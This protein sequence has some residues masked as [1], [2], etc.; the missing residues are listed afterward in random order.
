MGK[1]NWR[2]DAGAGPTQNAAYGPERVGRTYDSKLSTTRHRWAQYA[3]AG[4][5]NDTVTAPFLAHH[6]AL[7]EHQTRARHGAVERPRRTTAAIAWPDDEDTLE[8]RI[9]DRS[10][11]EAMTWDHDPSVDANSETIEFATQKPA[12]DSGEQGSSIVRLLFAAGGARLLVLPVTGLCNLAIARLVTKAVGIDQFGVVMLV[13]TLCQLLM[14]A[15]L[16]TGAAVATA[17]AQ[18]GPDGGIERFRGTALTAMRTTIVS[19]LAL[20]FIAV[21]LGVLGLWPM[22]LG[23]TDPALISSVNLS[24][25][26][27]LSA[28]AAALPFA[29]GEAIL[30]GAGRI[31]EAVLFQGVAAP[32]ALVL[33]VV[34]KQLSAAPIAYAL[35]LPLGA[36]IATVGCALRA[37]AVDRTAVTGL[38]RKVPRIRRFRGLPIAGTAV[39][40][41]VVMIGLPIALQSDR[42]VLAHRLDSESLAN[43]SYAAQLYTPL[44]SVISVAALALWPHFAAGADDGSSLRKGWMTGMAILGSGGVA[45]GLCFLIFARFVIGWMSDGQSH[46]TSSLLIAFAL[47]LIV[48]AVHVTSGILLIKPGQLRFQAACVIALVVANLPLS[49]LLAPPLGAAGPVFASA[50]TVFACQLVPG[51]LLAWRSTRQMGKAHD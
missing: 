43:Y 16:G 28:F 29:V 11:R 44:W 3:Q 41:F 4:Y 23:V 15:D 10:W 25:V 27:A 21:M 12:E 2:P 1:H 42:I 34:F 7:V 20:S 22:L 5:S 50:I 36:L 17:R 46:P 33:T 38:V 6:Q 18:A 30:R 49:W 48:Q 35:V 24:S 51:V 13:A 14:F 32:V 47:L 39:P 45:A 26:L 37:F 31:H 40:M 8:I 9:P 19:G